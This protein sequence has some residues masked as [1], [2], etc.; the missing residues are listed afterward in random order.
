M[1]KKEDISVEVLAKQVNDLSAK[2][3]RMSANWKRFC[4]KFIGSSAQDGKVGS[5]RLNVLLTVALLGIAVSVLA[6]V[7]HE[8]GDKFHVGPAVIRSNGDYDSEGGIYASGAITVGG[9]ITGT[10]VMGKLTNALSTVSGSDVDYGMV[11]QRTITLA[12]VPVAMIYTNADDATE[13]CGGVKIAGF[14]EGRILVHGVVVDNLRFATNAAML[15][16]NLVAYGLGTT[17][18]TYSGLSTA[19][20]VN[21]APTN[22]LAQCINSN[23]VA[24][25]SAAQFDGTATPVSIYLNTKR[26]GPGI[27]NYVSGTAYVTYTKLGD[28]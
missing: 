8:S 13:V 7:A 25:A 4:S 28:Y 18:V 6:D 14:E 22:V 12:S 3:R 27:T 15:K 20:E 24:L 2:V 26:E 9:A 21:F 5:V 17:A 11:R 19:T 23:D 1:E 16:T 10:S